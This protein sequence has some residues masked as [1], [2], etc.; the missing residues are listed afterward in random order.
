MGTGKLSETRLLVI[1]LGALVLVPA[2]RLKAADVYVVR[3][4]T[5]ITHNSPTECYRV[6]WRDHLLFR[7]TTNQSLMVQALSASNGHT[8]SGSLLVPARSNRSVII[9]LR[10]GENG[11]TNSWAPGGSG[12]FV[13]NRLDVPHGILVES[14]AELY[15]PEA[16]PLPCQAPPGSSPSPEVFGTM[17]LPVVRSLIPA[18]SEH[19]HLATDLG[20]E[21]SRTN[22]GIYNGGSLAAT[23]VVEVRRSCDDVVVEARTVNIP[24]DSVTQ[25]YGFIDGLGAS[26]GCGSPGTT[27]YSR[28]VS[29]VMTQPGFSFVTTLARDLPPRIAVTA[30]VAR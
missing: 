5:H 6:G 4:A 18:G 30:S 14:R 28:Y 19:V 25:A 7:N 22:V 3:F 24:A 2:V 10:G 16:T 29:V 15:G 9:A 21:R 13:V 20:T 17:A 1:L 11:V 12:V 26:P 23:A 27:Q 8:P